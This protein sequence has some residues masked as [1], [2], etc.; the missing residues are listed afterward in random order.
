MF[1]NPWTLP[2][3]INTSFFSLKKVFLK[4]ENFLLF[5]IIKDEKTNSKPTNSLKSKK[6]LNL[7]ATIRKNIKKGKQNKLYSFMNLES[8]TFD[9]KNC[10]TLIV[11]ETGIRILIVLAKSYPRIKN[12]GVPNNSRPTP[13]IDWTIIK[14]IIMLISKND[15]ILINRISPYGCN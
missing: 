15:I 8:L 4:A 5:N 3:P 7:S 1:V 12:D 9:F 14:K 10:K 6:F 2:I 13:K 11:I